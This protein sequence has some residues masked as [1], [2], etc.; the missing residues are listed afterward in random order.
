[1]VACALALLLCPQSTAVPRLLVNAIIIIMAEGCGGGGGGGTPG[2]V[3]QDNRLSGFSTPKGKS[4]FSG[5]CDG[6]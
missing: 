5:V 2:K 1:V 4:T 3:T 6:H